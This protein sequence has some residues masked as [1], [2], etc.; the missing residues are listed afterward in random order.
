M[1]K[2]SLLPLVLLFPLLNSCGTKKYYMAL[3]S[4]TDSLITNISESIKLTGNSYFVNEK[5]QSGELFKI[6]D[7]NASFYQDGKQYPFFTIAEKASMFI[8]NIGIH[9]FLPSIE[10]DVE[11]NVL[12]YD[13]DLIEKQLEIYDYHFQHIIE[14]IRLI[15]G[16]API[17]VLSAYNEYTFE[18]PEKMLF[19]TIINKI[20]NTMQVE[21]EGV[22]NVKFVSTVKIQDE[23]YKDPNVNQESLMADIIRSHYNE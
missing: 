22:N 12:N 16:K 6:T 7:S 14:E 8:I 1:K 9:D 13:E 15:N 21:L 19:D 5:M 2:R 4:F 11:N 3:G 10:I 20:N 23:I 18:K 17:Y